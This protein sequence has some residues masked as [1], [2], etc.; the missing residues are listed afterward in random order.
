M[1]NRDFWDNYYKKETGKA[2]KFIND[3]LLNLKKGSCLDIACGDGINS[4]FLSNNGFEQVEGIDFSSV[5]IEKCKAL[6]LKNS[7]F[8]TQSLDFYLAPIQKYDT[9]LVIDYKASMRLIEEL[10]KGLKIGGTLILENYTTEHVRNNLDFDIEECYKPFELIKML[11][12]WN[13]LYYDEIDK[14]KVKLLAVKPSY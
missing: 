9:I 14:N 10:K 1:R 4:S 6:N 13:I 11:K 3:F 2:S 12:S 5:A 8:K 7:D